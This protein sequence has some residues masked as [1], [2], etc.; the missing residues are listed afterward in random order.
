VLA[1]LRPRSAY[2]VMAALALFVALS[3]GSAYAI[4]EWTGANIVDESLTGADVRGK[5]PAGTTPAVNGSL[6]SQDV[7]GQQA[8]A[9]SGTP[10]IDGTLTQWDIKNGAVAGSDIASN[11]I[12]GAKVADNALNGADVANNGLTG[13]D[14]DEST[15]GQVPSALVGGHGRYIGGQQCNP[16]LALF[17]TCA[18]VTLDI[19]AGLPR[20]HVIGVGSAADFIDS[21]DDGFYGTCR[22]ATSR[23]SIP[24]SAVAVASGGPVES[25]GAQG[26]PITVTAITSPLTA[27]QVAFAIECNESLYNFSLVNVGVTAVVIAPN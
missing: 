12:T 13:A 25:P 24:E 4:N 21:G 8:H 27:G 3:T 11:A 19:P 7:A 15:L 9:S 2:D 23:G 18:V 6:T 26:I 5:A 20:V 22:V 17:I 14:I 16:D 1:K 10:F